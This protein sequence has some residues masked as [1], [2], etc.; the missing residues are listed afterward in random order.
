[1]FNLQQGVYSLDVRIHHRIWDAQKHI[2]QTLI[3]VKEKIFGCQIIN[4]T[5]EWKV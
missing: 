1:M 2:L 3:T 5:V 4:L